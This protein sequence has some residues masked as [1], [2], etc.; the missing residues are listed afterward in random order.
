MK[1]TKLSVLLVLTLTIVSS[2]VG[3]DDAESHYQYGSVDDTYEDHAHR[4][5]AGIG[6]NFFNFAD[7]VEYDMGVIEVNK[8]DFFGILFAHFPGDSEWTL[9]HPPFE[10]DISVEDDGY[11]V[12]TGAYFEDS[13]QDS[14]RTEFSRFTFEANSEGEF[15]LHFLFASSVERGK[16]LRHRS[17]RGHQHKYGD[18]PIEEYLAEFSTNLM[19]KVVVRIDDPYGRK[20]DL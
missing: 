16:F 6:V 1:G 8:G 9:L 4:I 14:E 11:G 5:R 17:H 15:E 20:S 7:S 12:G 13:Y 2:V 18:A 3:Q 19:R 10:G